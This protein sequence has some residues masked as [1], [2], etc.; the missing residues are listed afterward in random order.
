MD[1]SAIILAEGS[2]SG[3]SEDK[4]LLKLDGKPLL[5]HVVNAVKG[6]VGEVLVVTASKEQA[7]LYAKVVSSANVQFAVT[8]DEPQGSLAAALAGFEAAKG[9]YSLVLPFD[10]PFVSKEVVSLL[11]E[12]SGG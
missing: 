8:E 2:H 6:I 1:R 12:L 3:F 4:A 5:N 7:N 11:F 9:D 10:A